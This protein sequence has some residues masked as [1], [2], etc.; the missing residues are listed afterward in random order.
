MGIA[1]NRLIDNLR[2]ER[3]HADRRDDVEV[4]DIPGPGDVERV[5]DRMLVASV[6]EELPDRARKVVE[7]A[8]FDDLTQTQIA[9][10]TGLPLG[11]VKSDTRRALQRMRETLESAR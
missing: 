4:A 6:L 8:Y 2:S 3:R 7:L 5:G 9:E 1:K 11:T 10:R